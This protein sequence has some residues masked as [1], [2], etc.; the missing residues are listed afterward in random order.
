MANFQSGGVYK[1]INAQAGNCVDLSG[2]DNTSVIG[3]DYHG[4]DNQ[5]VRPHRLQQCM[6]SL[7]RSSCAVA[8]R[9]AARRPR[10]GDPECRHWQIPLDQRGCAR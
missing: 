3:F 4:G 1:L 9:E 7:I 5:K 10:L 2:G 8:L 6:V